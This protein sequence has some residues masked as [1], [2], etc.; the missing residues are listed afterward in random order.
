[1]YENQSATVRKDNLAIEKILALDPAG[2]YEIC[3]KEKISMCGLGPTVAMLSALR[4]AGVSRADLV[5][6]ATS[7][8]YSGDTR[9]VVG[10]AGFLFS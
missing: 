2:L 7:A 5:R 10:Y 9:K 8:D 4:H 1:H 3:R 6:Q